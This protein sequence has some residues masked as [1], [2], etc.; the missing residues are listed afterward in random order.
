MSNL[1]HILL[2]LF[3]F[4]LFYFWGVFNYKKKGLQYWLSALFP[5]I[6]V[7]FILGSRTWGADYL[8][9]KYQFQHAF[10][11]DM[12][13]EQQPLFVY[14]NR[15]L[16][17]LGLNYV[18]AFTVYSV[19]YFVATF[20]LFKS[21]GDY[22]KYMYAFALPAYIGFGTDIVR[23]TIAIGLILFVI[24]DFNKQKYI[25]A[26]L[27]LLLAVM[28]HSASVILFVFYLFFKII[29]KKELSPLIT[30]PLYF[31][32]I[33]AF[34]PEWL[35]GLNNLI[36]ELNL[37]NSKFQGYIDNSDRWFSEEANN[38]IYTQGILPLILNTGFVISLFYLGYRAILKKKQ[39]EFIII[40]NMV[41]I[42]YIGLR[43]FFNVE[44]LRRFFIPNTML[45]P[46]VLGY[47][48]YVLKGKP[49]NAV[50]KNLIKGSYVLVSIWLILYWGRWIF[51]YPDGN[52]FWN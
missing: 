25:S 31:L 47:A 17:F 8:W 30:I 51:M 49:N 34:K 45:Y 44:I 48:I 20:K 35:N 2:F 50:E 43:L 11:Y 3:S 14:F 5:L 7:C 37:G 36:S 16:H 27:F 41:V 6:I 4:L 21:F 9:Y 40:Y 38:N 23:Q 46:I 19:I 15:L 22:S 42:G 29:Y 1:D 52:F 24:L 18:G 12:L 13:K 26:I 10:D 32:V 33:F 39:K 28:I